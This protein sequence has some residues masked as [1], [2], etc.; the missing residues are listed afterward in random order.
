MKE[1]L[2]TFVFLLLAL[3]KIDFE[4][5]PVSGFERRFSSYSSRMTLQTPFTDLNAHPLTQPL[6][7]LKM[8]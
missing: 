1:R 3:S 6:K 4:P 8:F 2:G 5:L 7:S